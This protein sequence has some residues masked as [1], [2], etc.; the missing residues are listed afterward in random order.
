MTTNPPHGT[1]N[2]ITALISVIRVGSTFLVGPTKGGHSAVR[3]T[4]KRSETAWGGLVFTVI[5]QHGWACDGEPQTKWVQFTW[6]HMSQY[7]IRPMAYIRTPSYVHMYTV[8]TPLTV[9]HAGQYI[10]YTVNFTTC[11][12]TLDGTVPWKQIGRDTTSPLPVQTRLPISTP[13]VYA[14]T[15][16]VVCTC[17]WLCTHLK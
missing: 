2:T 8:Q 10:L 6:V 16:L 5:S 15:E 14:T 12:A 3:L 13:C 17:S 1:H 7:S 11:V 4:V 9:D